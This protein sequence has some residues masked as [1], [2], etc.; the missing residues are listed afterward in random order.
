MLSWKNVLKL[1]L[2]VSLFIGVPVFAKKQAHTQN[3]NGILATS[4]LV[5]DIDTGE[6]LIE[7]NSQEIRSIA[8]ITKLMSAMV[9][10]DADTD[11]FEIL[12]VIPIK[13][14]GSKLRKTQMTRKDLLTLSLMSSDN[15]AAKTLA[16]NYPGGEVA[17]VIA[18]NKKAVRIGMTRSSFVEPTGLN[19]DNVS[20]SEDL[21]KL[22]EVAENYPVIKIASTSIQKRV[23][24]IEK[25]KVR[26]LEFHTTNKLVTSIPEI[27]ISKTGWI[28]NSGGCLIMSIHQRGRRLIV[29]LLNSKNTHTRIRDAELLY[30]LQHGKN[31]RTS[32]S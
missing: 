5:K 25:K 24:I 12:Q 1:L 22:L 9:I 14:I 16:I 4:Y 11:L 3:N 7:K 2:T 13:G 10:L 17:H 23:E 30:G 28:R 20:T 26:Y 21:S 8:S 6:I 19:D 32:R 15:L 29:I 31:I 18:M 27:V